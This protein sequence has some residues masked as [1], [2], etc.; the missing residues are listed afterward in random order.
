[1]RRES[2]DA[3]L[4]WFL[5]VTL[6]KTSLFVISYQLFKLTY[7]TTLIFTYRIIYQFG[8]IELLRCH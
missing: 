4:I 3:D 7:I 8:F 5:Y 1:M 6:L 2:L